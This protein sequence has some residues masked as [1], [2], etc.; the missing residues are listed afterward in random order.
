M[1]RQSLSRFAATTLLLL[2]AIATTVSAVDSAPPVAGSLSAP[3]L[4]EPAARWFYEVVDN[5][6]NAGKFTSIAVDGSGNPHIS[7]YDAYD[8]DLEYAHKDASGWH[9]ETVDSAGHVGL[10]TS[11]AL[12]SSDQAHISYY[13]EN[14]GGLRY[15]YQMPDG[16]HIKDVDG[17]LTDVGR[18]S[19]IAVDMYNG[20]HIAYQDTT[21]KNLKY[22]RKEGTTPHLYSFGVYS[23]YHSSV[24]LWQ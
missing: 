16:W 20:P 23:S 13:F 4:A 8:H 24:A 5:G 19:S 2:L 22:M 15:A 14:I 21:K 6:A 12:D 3:D 9:L 18:Y 10:Y 11:I 17:A 1:K 7:Y